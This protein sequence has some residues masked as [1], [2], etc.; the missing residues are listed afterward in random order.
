MIW[1]A[2]VTKDTVPLAFILV[3]FAG[4]N[5]APKYS[6]PTFP[7]PPSYK[8]VAPDQYKE[9][10]GW[11]IADP[12]DDKIRPK[13]W[14]MYNDP[15]LNELEEQVQ[16]S[17][18]SITAAEANYRAARAVVVQA[19][20]ALVPTV[21]AGP[22]ITNSR[23]SSTRGALASSGTRGTVGGGG[24]F[25]SGVITAYD[26]PIDVSYTV[27]LWHKVRN[28][29]AANAF[30]AQASAAEVATALLSTQAELA[31][32][33][34]QLRALDQQRAILQETIENDQQMLQLVTSLY[35]AG[36]DSQEEVAQAQTQLDTTTAQATDLGVARAQ[37]EHAIATLIGK[38]AAEFS[39]TVGTFRPGPPAVP[40]AVPSK[41]LERRPDIAAAERQVAA[42]NA[43]IGVAKAAY[44]PNL[45]LSAAAGFEATNIADW[46]TWPSRF[47]S[48][49]PQLAQ[50]L[51]EG[52]A[53]RGATEQA[54][55]SYD[56]AVAN[57]RQTVLTDFQS[58]EDNLAA[59]RILAQ[60]VG[61][62]HEAVASSE[63]YLNLA[64]TRFQAGIDSYLNVI[65]AENTLLSN[66]V[67]EL[68]VQLRQM[69]SSVNL[70]LALGGGWDVSELPQVQVV[71]HSPKQKEKLREP[72]QADRVAPPNPPPLA[73]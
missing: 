56:A 22:S 70:I 37:Y 60:E 17:N 49:G 15:R 43:Q 24:A 8:E 59:L 6:R 69:T 48:V 39:L 34:F 16:I 54:Q 23:I 73:H 62:Q 50:T 5:P 9:V 61:Q 38:P 66:R 55:A 52:G 57:Y 2:R 28:T 67:A 3:L 12:S 64:Q 1:G 19:R 20:S 31:Q 11:K 4:C 45:T 47:W 14:E 46:F 25:G 13:W 40:V 63:Y 53:R 41:V 72:P 44:Y 35:R 26:L 42:A 29:V 27:D 65:T 21:T 51:F 18:Q 32:D 58:V 10:A 33:Y 71:S 36:V 68:Q 30:T 7:A